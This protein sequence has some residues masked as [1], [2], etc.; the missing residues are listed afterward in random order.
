MAGGV[1]DQ[2]SISTYA[3]DFADEESL[4]LQQA[5]PAA[6]PS[7]SLENSYDNS[8][9]SRSSGDYLAEEE[10]KYGA[11]SDDSVAA[12]PAADASVT[13]ASVSDASVSDAS[14][15]GKAPP[16]KLIDSSE[17][18][19]S[20]D[21]ASTSSDEK[22]DDRQSLDT[23]GKL[24]NNNNGD[25]NNNSNNNSG[26]EDEAASEI[27]SQAQQPSRDEDDDGDASVDGIGGGAVQ[28]GDGGAS[29]S[30][31]APT[32]VRDLE[33]RLQAAKAE[34]D[35]L[36]LAIEKSSRETAVDGS[37]GKELEMLKSQVEAA[38]SDIYGWYCWYRIIGIV[39]QGIHIDSTTVFHLRV[40]QRQSVSM[41]RVFIAGELQ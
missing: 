33:E 3:D 2:Q 40:H 5:E 7:K 31:A 9:A 24:A 27:F 8:T 34:N 21:A 6:P 38:R 41:H 26:G 29:L 36:R 22:N 4:T 15:A 39:I 14:V 28:H 35:K 1:D 11:P 17:K 18:R 10:G 37:G 20:G 25:G 13:D 19:A 16:A 23:P 12:A 30:A 32:S